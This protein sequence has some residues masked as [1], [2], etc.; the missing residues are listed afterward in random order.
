MEDYDILFS[1]LGFLF[2]IG[3]IILIIIESTSNNT[4]VLY[5]RR[6]NNNREY[7]NNIRYSY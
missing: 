2:I 6:H 5:I 3:L 4:N 7:L 1:I